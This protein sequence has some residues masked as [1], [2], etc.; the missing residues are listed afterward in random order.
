MVPL[1]ICL[2]TVPVTPRVCMKR[3]KKPHLEFKMA[4]NHLLNLYCNN[5]CKHEGNKYPYFEYGK[6]NQRS[7]WIKAGA[8]V[9]KA[10][11][12]RQ[13]TE[14]NSYTNAGRYAG[15][16]AQPDTSLRSEIF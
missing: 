5:I 3:K 9:R 10:G 16:K 15:D 11:V 6:H 7:D 2:C 12:V 13:L 14:I 4:D 8:I 1:I